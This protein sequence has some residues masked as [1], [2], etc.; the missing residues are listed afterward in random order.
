MICGVGRGTL[1]DQNT[2]RG[3][4]GVEAGTRGLASNL[5]ILVVSNL[6]SKWFRLLF[7]GL[8]DVFDG[9]KH[10]KNVLTVSL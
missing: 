4:G 10:I 9:K 6:Y 1:V 8:G 2:L 3:G 7:R 5:N